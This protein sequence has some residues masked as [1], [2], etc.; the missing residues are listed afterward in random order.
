MTEQ[1]HFTK[2]TLLTNAGDARDTCLITGL[3]RSPRVGNDNPLQ[4][5]YWENPMSRGAWQ[6]MVHGVAESDTT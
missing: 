6:A 4:Y 5:S 3:G 1:L 2:L